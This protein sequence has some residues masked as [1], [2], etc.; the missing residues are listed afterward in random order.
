MNDMERNAWHGAG[1]SLKFEPSDF[2]VIDLVLGLIPELRICAT[3]LKRARA[4]QLAY[5]VNS[6]Q[7][8]FGLLEN[9][10]FSGGGHEFG[11]K[12]MKTFLSPH[13]FPIGNEGELVSR[14]YIALMRCKL[15]ENSR[16]QSSIDALKNQQGFAGRLS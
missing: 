6:V 4:A 13:F 3:A 8:L 5:P 11:T 2:D 1:S 12:D 9:R 10:R 14:I 16:T 7:E 15:E